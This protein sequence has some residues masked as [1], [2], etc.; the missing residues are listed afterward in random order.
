MTTMVIWKCPVK[1]FHCLQ[2]SLHPGNR[3][4]GRGF[5]P[6]ATLA[7]LGSCHPREGPAAKTPGRPDPGPARTSSR[8][9]RYGRSDEGGGDVPRG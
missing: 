4:P 7:P 9:R 2:L 1:S 8:L 6:S 5:Y 3:P